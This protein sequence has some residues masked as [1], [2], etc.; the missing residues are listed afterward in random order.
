MHARRL[1][2]RGTRALSVFGMLA[3]L[4]AAIAI[5]IAQL[6]MLPQAVAGVASPQAGSVPLEDWQRYAAWHPSW[7]YVAVQ[8]IEADC[9]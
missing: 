7:H 6:P 2:S 5:L 1:H 4:L 9:L 8:G 3:S